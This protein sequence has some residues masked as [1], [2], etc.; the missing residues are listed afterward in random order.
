M[1]DVTK[2]HTLGRIVEKDSDVIWGIGAIDE[3]N[4]FIGL[5]KVFSKDYKVKDLLEK[6]QT[7]MFAAG[8]EFASS[9]TRITENDYIE[10]LET[11]KELEKEVKLPNEFIILEQDEVTAYL[12]VARSVVRR[13]E[14]WAVKLHKKGVVSR[15]LVEW[16][17]KLSYL[18]Y[19]MILKEM[20]GN[21]KKVDMEDKK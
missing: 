13:A 7:K 21:Y 17:N 5:A 10:M 1:K 2:T 18:L 8:A 19:L 9:Q 12:S 6:I 11:I 15:M 16:L 4:A 14:R 3:A 20:G